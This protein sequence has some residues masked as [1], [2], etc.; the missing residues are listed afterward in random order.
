MD[1]T[2]C[3]EPQCLYKGD[4]Y[5]NFTHFRPPLCFYIVVYMYCKYINAELEPSNKLQATPDIAPLFSPTSVALYLNTQYQ[6][7]LR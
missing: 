1:R 7:T 3:T 4:L 5:I 6:L 2:A